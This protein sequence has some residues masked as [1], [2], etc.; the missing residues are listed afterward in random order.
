MLYFALAVKIADTAPIVSLLV[1]TD[2]YRYSCPV[3][4]LVCLV[5]LLLSVWFY[6][7][8]IVAAQCFHWFATKQAMDELHRVLIP[9]GKLGTS[10][11]E[12]NFSYGV[13]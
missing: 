2:N 13:L 7:Q 3:L 11:L 6:L 12:V 9:G 4:P 5:L 10:A 1:F 8:T